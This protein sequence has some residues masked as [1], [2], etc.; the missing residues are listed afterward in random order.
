MRSLQLR[1]RKGGKGGKGGSSGSDSGKQG[2]TVI[3]PIRDQ[4]YGGGPLTAEQK[5]E[6]TVVATLAVL[7]F[8]ILAEGIFVAGSV[9]MA[10]L[11]KR[12][13]KHLALPGR[14]ERCLPACLPSLP[15]SVCHPGRQ[16]SGKSAAVQSYRGVAPLTPPVVLRLPSSWRRAS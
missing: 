8:V 16:P 14:T 13:Q 2:P 6:N 1:R 7:F 15:A 9:S 5:A 3:S 10:W 12:L 11:K 4:V